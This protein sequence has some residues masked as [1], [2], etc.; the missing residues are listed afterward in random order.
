MGA[1]LRL[2][3]MVAGSSG[4]LGSRIVEHLANLSIEVVEID[5]K[6]FWSKLDVTEASKKSGGVF[7]FA[8]GKVSHPDTL[9][10][11]NGYISDYEQLVAQGLSLAQKLNCT[12]FIH[13]SS[14]DVYGSNEG[15]PF[16]ES[17]EA[18]PDSPYG[19]SRLR[20][21]KLVANWSKKFSIETLILRPFLIS[22]SEQPG[23]FLSALVRD[24]A[25]GREFQVQ[26]P[27]FVR[28]FLAVSDFLRLLELAIR[29]SSPHGLDTVN[30]CSSHAK[31]LWEIALRAQDLIGGTVSRDH[32]DDESP[33]LY[34]I[35]NNHKARDLWGWQPKIISSEDLI[36]EVKGSHA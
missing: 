3:V 6:L 2:K 33:K 25:E 34:R 22:G 18:L 13:L 11:A 5:R 28:D 8:A 29:H 16:K 1:V 9:A 35:G 27:S 12:R 14:G 10:S 17:D 19:L 4:Y 26:N 31:G 30:A 36:R 24:L 23:R 20:G 32:R 15:E 21:E 7:I